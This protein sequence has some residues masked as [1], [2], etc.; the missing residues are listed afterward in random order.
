MGQT[1]STGIEQG[2]DAARAA[3]REAPRAGVRA[4]VHAGGPGSLRRD[5]VGSPRR[6]HRER[7]R[8]GRVRAAG[9]GSARGSGRSRRRTSWCRS[10]FRGAV[11]TPDREWSVRQLISRVVDTI[12]DWAREQ[13]LLRDRRRTCRRSATS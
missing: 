4:G 6:R 13:R 7:A 1:G 2:A 3:G 8:R 5:R 11:G 12:A 10:S 9:R